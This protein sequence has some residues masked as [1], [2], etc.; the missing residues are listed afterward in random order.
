M[1]F[2]FDQIKKAEK[3]YVCGFSTKVIAEEVGCDKTTI[4]T[5]AKTLNWEIAFGE[6]GLK[7]TRTVMNPKNAVNIRLST[8]MA[9]ID[10]T[11]EDYEEISKLV[12]YLERIEKIKRESKISTARANKISGAK[13]MSKKIN[14]NFLGIDKEKLRDKF[15]KSQYEYQFEM[16]QHKGI[17]VRNI[18]KS[19]QVGFT[20]Y[21]AAEAFVDALETGENQI[22]ISASKSQ[23][24]VFKDYIKDFAVQWFEKELCGRDKIELITDKGIAI[25]YFLSANSSTAQS[26]SGNFYF[27]EYFWTRDFQR[28]HKV[29]GAMASQK[30]FRKTYFSTPSAM[31]HPAYDIWSGDQYNE[32]FRKRNQEAVEFP[33][34][35]ELEKGVICPDKSF[36]KIITIHE[37]IKRGCDLFD[38]DDLKEEYTDNEF[39]QLFECEFIDDSNSLFQLSV[40]QDCLSDISDWR[41]YKPEWAKPF[42]EKPVWIGYDPSRTRDGACIAVVAP[43]KKLGGKFRVLE[44][45]RMYGQ[46]WFYQSEKIRI[47]TEKYTVDNI[48]I[49]VTGPGSG[50]FEQ[51]KQ[52]YPRARA[53]HYT[54]EN[55]TRLV[56][57]AQDVIWQGRIL[58]DSSWSDIAAGFMQIRRTT[59]PNGQITFIAD[60]SERTGHAD[61]AWAIMHALINEGLNYGKEKSSI[62]SF[63]LN[64]D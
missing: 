51:V 43:P 63:G 36:R 18:L 20:R 22:F 23:T 41:D 16:N 64:D 30:R 12:E 37:A 57:K 14:N 42:G 4:A 7:T 17:R 32:R 25:L 38:I 44:R 40:L 2:S 34:R 6:R 21:F 56:L 31:S 13:K 29:A 55:K 35:K 53:I 11:D 62:Y 9:K 3:M 60:R 27:D 50:V 8:L 28:L 47:L 45:I 48:S 58:W 39:R 33:K 26:Y 52:F 1:T 54:L 10:K 15:K 24:E 19:R 46:T 61:S 59:T 5:W 49:D